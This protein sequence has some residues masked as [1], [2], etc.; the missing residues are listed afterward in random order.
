MYI[1]Y[2]TFSLNIHFLLPEHFL[3]I[4]AFIWHMFPLNIHFLS[5]YIFF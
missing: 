1:I 5:T 2:I 3:L 4:Y